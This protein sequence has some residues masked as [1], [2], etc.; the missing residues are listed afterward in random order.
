ML[1]CI[2][3]TPAPTAIARRPTSRSASAGL[4]RGRSP[5][6]RSRR[7]SVTSAW[8]VPT[9]TISA[10]H[11]GGAV[12]RGAVY[13]IDIPGYG[14]GGTGAMVADAQGGGRWANWAAERK[15]PGWIG[16]LANSA[17]ALAIV[18]STIGFLYIAE[19]LSGAGVKAAAVTIC[20]LAA[21]AG[22]TA[23]AAQW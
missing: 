14:S 22:V 5:P 23:F 15:P 18:G 21:F 3:S 19:L 10:L 4:R 8:S 6:C 2:A 11:P 12:R 17:L 20:W 7:R 16:L 13:D 1:P 9:A